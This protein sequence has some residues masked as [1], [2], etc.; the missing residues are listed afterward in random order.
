MV[1]GVPL[2]SLRPEL[3]PKNALPPSFAAVFSTVR[4]RTFLEELER[5]LGNDAGCAEA[6]LASSPRVK[7]S[8]CGDVSSVWTGFCSGGLGGCADMIVVV[9]VR[10]CRRR[11]QTQRRVRG[12][13][14]KADEATRHCNWTGL[15]CRTRTPDRAAQGEL[16]V[17][18]KRQMR[19]ELPSH[20]AQIYKSHLNFHLISIRNFVNISSASEGVHNG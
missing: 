5:L 19:V 6:G 8:V 3:L 12:G 17:E 4:L 14:G 18:R 1:T 13:R 16:Q 2:L 10:R 7:P 20:D 9:I 15:G 11:Q